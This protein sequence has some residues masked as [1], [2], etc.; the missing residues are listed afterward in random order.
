MCPRLG[1][2]DASNPQNLRRCYYEAGW[3]PPNLTVAE[4]AF[5]YGWR[6]ANVIRQK[7]ERW[8]LLPRVEPVRRLVERHRETL[9][10]R[11]PGGRC[12]LSGGQS[13]G[14]RQGL[15]HQGLRRCHN[16][17]TTGTPA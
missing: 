17:Q 3:R 13:E 6:Q 9:S 1:S 10:A 5:T 15:D 7:A 11:I 12:G 2:P 14:G 4:G 8:Q 16:L